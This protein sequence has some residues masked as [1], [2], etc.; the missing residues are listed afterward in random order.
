MN[1]VKRAWHAVKRFCSDN[2][3][4]IGIAVIGGSL[5]VSQSAFATTAGPS[6][7]FNDASFKSTLT[8]IFTGAQSMFTDV[9]PKSR[10]PSITTHLFV[11]LT[12]H[13]STP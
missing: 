4:V 7:T 13:N 12:A 5:A 10:T 6:I 11:E 8:S 2:K 1:V 3:E 9:M